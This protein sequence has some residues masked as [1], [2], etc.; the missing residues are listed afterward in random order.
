MH[1]LTARQKGNAPEDAISFIFT[2][3]LR[4]LRPPPPAKNAT[5]DLGELE[6]RNGNGRNG[7][8]RG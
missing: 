1:K 5:V 4:G 2:V 6:E 8:G 3:G 7:N